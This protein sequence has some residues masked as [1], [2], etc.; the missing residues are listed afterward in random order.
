MRLEKENVNI[1]RLLRR[2]A[3]MYLRGNKILTSCIYKQSLIIN[4]E[5]KT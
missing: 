1:I 5:K 3:K 2:Y 4:I